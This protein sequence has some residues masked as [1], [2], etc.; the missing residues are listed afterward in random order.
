MSQASPTHQM[1]T[2]ERHGARLS[3]GGEARFASNPLSC[4]SRNLYPR[5]SNAGRACFDQLRRVVLADALQVIGDASE[6]CPLRQGFTSR[7]LL[8]PVSTWMTPP[9]HGWLLTVAA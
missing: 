1:P 8:H 7:S 4:H 9:V 3:R 5:S 2:R 6:H